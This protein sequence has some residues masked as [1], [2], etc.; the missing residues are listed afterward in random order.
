M[1][2]T[3]TELPVVAPSARLADVL[4]MLTEGRGFDLEL[5]GWP[6]RTG[7]TARLK[8]LTAA[9][10]R[11]RHTPPRTD[12][13]TGANG[14][15]VLFAAELRT[16]LRAGDLD[17]ATEAATALWR[18]GRSLDRVYAV[19][20]SVIDTALKAV[21]EAAVEPAPPFAPRA[22]LDPAGAPSAADRLARVR[23]VDV[24]RRLVDQLRAAAADTPADSA[25]DTP[26]PAPDVTS[27]QGA[28]ATALSCECV[29]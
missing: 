4:D 23:T 13:A 17:R 9:V 19:V 22:A 15:T 5:D 10:E 26:A 6:P 3:V 7:P 18:R 21:P 2:A 12:R 11:T 29:S 27:D 20:Y 24:A 14:L 1:S 8:L 25:A 28:S 16:A